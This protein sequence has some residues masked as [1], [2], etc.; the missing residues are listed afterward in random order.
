M[1][2]RA[3]RAQRYASIEMET[4]ERLITAEE[5]LRRGEQK[6]VEL[7]AGRL[8]MD[9]PT[10]WHQML[11]ARLVT[12]LYTWTQ[13]APGRGMALPAVNVRLDGYNVFGP[14]LSWISEERRPSLDAGSIEAPDLVV[15]IRS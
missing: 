4:A 6:F 1:D 11:Q 2:A 13:A 5:Y 12:A 10:V 9:E 15:E 3:R 7:V 8:V 14:D